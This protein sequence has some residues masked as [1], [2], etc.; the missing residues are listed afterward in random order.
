MFEIIAVTN[1]LLCKGGFLDRIALLSS[2]GVSAV[3]LREKDLSEAQYLTL[4]RQTEAICKN[5]DLEFVPHLFTASARELGC[6]KLHLPFSAFTGRIADGEDLRCFA[7]GVSVHSVE[8]ARFAASHGA[9]Y[10]V[11]GHIFQTGC[12]PGLEP[13]GLGFLAEICGAVSI[14]VYAIGGITKAHIPALRNAGA[15]GA[16]FMSSLMQGSNTAYRDT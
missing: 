13:R 12:K 1:R 9:Q 14:P 16:C 2:F 5:H 4:A 7:V 6:R 11:A 10:L 15:S 8:E 3:I